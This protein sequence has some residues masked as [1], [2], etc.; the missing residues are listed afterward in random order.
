MDPALEQFARAIVAGKTP[1]EAYVSAAVGVT[2]RSLPEATAE[3][4]ALVV[5]LRA[6]APAVPAVPAVRGH[7]AVRELARKYT[8]EAIQGL[9]AIGQDPLAPHSA[10]AMAWC[11]VLDRGHGK[12]EQKHELE[13][14]VFEGLPPDKREILDAA[15]E[16]LLSRAASPAVIDVTP[17]GRAHD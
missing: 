16:L 9:V 11:A 17:N 7:A 6:Q 2:G 1:R 4:A 3:T 13:V 12:P 14:S 8:V 15:C 10:R 5:E